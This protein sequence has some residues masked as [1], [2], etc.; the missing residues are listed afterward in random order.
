VDQGPVGAIILAALLLGGCGSPESRLRHTLASQTTGIIRLPR[1]EIEVSSELK[2]AAGAHD[3]EIVGNETRLKAADGFKGRAILVIENVERV[4]LHYLEI[5]GNRRKLAK[6]R[7]MAPPENV[8]RV[9]YPDNG[10]LVNNVS[11]LQIERLRLINIVNFPL[12]V[13][14]SSKVRVWGATVENSGSTNARGRNNLSG[15]ILFEEGSSEFEVTESVFRGILGNAL[16]T[17]SLFRAPRQ[18]DGMFTSNKFDTIGRDAIQVGHATRVRVEGN[19]GVNI[20]FPSSVVDIENQGIPIAID[21]AGNVD[22]SEYIGNTFEEINGQCIDLDGFHDGSVRDN[23]C[24]NRKAAVDYP[25][26]SFAIA[27]NN[28]HPDTTSSNIELSGNVMD[29]SKFGGLFLMGSGNKIIGNRFL[30]LNLAGCNENAKQF[31]CVYKA[32]E[33]EMLESGI[34]I[35]RGVGRLQEARG[36]VIQGNQI[37]GHGMKSRCIVFGPGVPRDSNSIAKNI[38]SDDARGR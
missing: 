6:P 24:T 15:G 38:C 23:R 9:W 13:S 19:T 25:F 37:S 7:E 34:Y 16:W 30:R 33:P 31:G 32:D 2:L 28:T 12:L 36:N 21:T 11:G 35:S 17:H 10:V 20:G 4:H 14:Q 18:Q 1:G 3:L 27:M 22:G 26:G 5:D 8:F 29:G